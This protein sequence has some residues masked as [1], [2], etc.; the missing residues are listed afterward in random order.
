MRRITAL[1]PV[2]ASSTNY[3][4]HALD[5]WIAAPQQLLASY[6][7]GRMKSARGG[8]CQDL[9]KFLGALGLIPPDATTY[10]VYISDLNVRFSYH[11]ISKHLDTS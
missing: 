7:Q 2:A 8:F 9:A 5:P 4:A 6:A 1:G 11:L 3:A 10:L